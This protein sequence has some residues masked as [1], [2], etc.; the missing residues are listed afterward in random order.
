MCS[1]EEPIEKKPFKKAMKRAMK[2]AMKKR[3]LTATQLE[4][5]RKGRESMKSKK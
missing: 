1:C 4:N 5:L 2:K 3:A